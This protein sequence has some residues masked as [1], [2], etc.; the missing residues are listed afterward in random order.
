[1]KIRCIRM[2]LVCFI[3]GLLISIPAIA[4]PKEEYQVLKKI[5]L[6]GEPGLTALARPSETGPGLGDVKGA[7]SPHRWS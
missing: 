7:R 1:M 2:V 4:S 3:L 6:G 5:T